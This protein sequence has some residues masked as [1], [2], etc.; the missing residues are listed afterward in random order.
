MALDASESH[1]KRSDKHSDSK[2]AA[3]L[4][5]VHFSERSQNLAKKRANFVKWASLAGK[6]PSSHTTRHASPKRAAQRPAPPRVLLEH[7]IC[8]VRLALEDAS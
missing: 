4:I 3:L 7:A 5:R 2:P 6:Y 1:P 8:Y